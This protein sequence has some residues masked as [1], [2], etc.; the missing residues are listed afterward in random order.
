MSLT[1]A[2]ITSKEHPCFDW[3][4]DSLNRALDRY[5]G[6]FEVLIVD[7]E[8]AKRPSSL[9][10]S[11]IRHVAPKPTVWSGPHRLTKEDFWSASNARNS[12]FCLCQTTHIAFCDDRC[13]VMPGW[14]EAVFRAEKDN[15]AVCGAYEKRTGMTVE[16]GV[17]K[18]G[19]IIT[20]E[21]CRLAYLNKIGHGPNLFDA[22]GNWMFGCTFALPLEWALAV[23]GFEELCDSLSMEDVIFGMHLANAGYPIKYDPSM[24]IVED[25]TPE[26]CGPV[27]KRTSKERWPNDTEDKGHAALKKFGSEKRAQHQW[28]L[29]QIREHVLKGGA[30]PIP[31]GPRTDWFDGQQLSD[32]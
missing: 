11:H 5:K 19:G 12:A 23:N 4:M 22:P 25:R 31:T 27:M 3:F 20:G 18:H 32:F 6:I 14:L 29:R 2:F 8:I 15:Y 16:N 24:K 13:V 17:I 28:D 10:S 30:W 9:T 7:A 21:D 1:I 26:H